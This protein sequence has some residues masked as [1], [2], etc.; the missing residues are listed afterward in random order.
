MSDGASDGAVDGVTAGAGLRFL[1]TSG[2]EIT[3]EAGRRVLIDPFLAGNERVPPSP[4]TVEELAG[5][6]LVLVTHGAYDHLG[7]AFDILAAGDATLVCGA[8]VRI[9]AIACGV[10][11]ERVAKVLPGTRLETGDGIAVKALPVSHL[12]LID[13]PAG[14]LS[15]PPLAFVVETDGGTRIFHSGDTSLVGDLRLFGELYRPHVVLL[16]V[17]ETEPM[18]APLPPDEAAIAADWL[19]AP[20]VVPMHFVPGDPEP[21]RFT[22]ALAQRRPDILVVHLAPGE[23]VTLEP[24]AP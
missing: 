19:D 21:A 16:C 12:S 20:L 1:G 18:T 2:F 24:A 15:G 6:D 7:Q 11:P 8:E 17:G 9:H 14:R 10:A 13:S 3:T 23:R 22:A 5:A 4:V